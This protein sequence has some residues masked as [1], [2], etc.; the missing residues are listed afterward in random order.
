MANASRDENGIPTLVA[1]SS[2][3][4][5]GIVRICA[6][7]SLHSLCVED[8]T[9]GTDFGNNNN[10]ANRDDNQVPVLIAVSSADGVTPVEVYADPVTNKILV[11]ST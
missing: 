2:V 4:G 11:Q 8:D 10:N 5:A 9:T 7:V 1:T 3:D 6:D